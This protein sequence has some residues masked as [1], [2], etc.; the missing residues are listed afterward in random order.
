[1]NKLTNVF[2]HFDKYLNLYY[3][4]VVNIARDDFDREIFL[5]IL[6]DQMNLDV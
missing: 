2:Y 3:L 4:Y 5:I 6:I 1:M